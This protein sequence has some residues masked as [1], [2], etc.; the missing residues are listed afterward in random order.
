MYAFKKFCS[1]EQ[2]L[3][4][5]EAAALLTDI[6]ISKEWCAPRDPLK[7]GSLLAMSKQDGSKPNAWMIKAA[8][9][10]LANNGYSPKTELERLGLEYGQEL[11]GQ[12]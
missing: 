2:G 10:H 12:E 3:T 4:D 7:G 6:A 11:H 9:Y 8:Y 1:M 5:A